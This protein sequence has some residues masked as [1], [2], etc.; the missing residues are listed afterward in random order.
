M[1]PI[2]S[3]EINVEKHVHQFLTYRVILTGTL[4]SYYI[5]CHT[6][7]HILIYEWTGFNYSLIIL[8]PRLRV[9]EISIDHS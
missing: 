5:I 1:K 2:I 4:K 3:I 9:S 6:I 7:K 8:Y